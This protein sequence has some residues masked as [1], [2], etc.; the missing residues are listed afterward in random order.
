MITLIFTFQY[1]YIQINQ[2]KLFGMDPGIFTFQYGYIQIFISLN[3]QIHIT[4]LY[5]P[6]WLYSNN[7]NKGLMHIFVFFTFQPG[8]I[9]I[10]MQWD[11]FKAL[12]AFTFQ[13]GYIQIYFSALVSHASTLYI[14]TWLYSNV[15]PYACQGS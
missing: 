14:P 9:Q 5:I 7:A 10:E 1:G 2:A 6:I 8:Y 15:C 12:L 3:L 13:P 4:A 11:E